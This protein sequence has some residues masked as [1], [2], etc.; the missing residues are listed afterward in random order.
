MSALLARAAARAAPRRRRKLVYSLLA[1]LVFVGLAPLAAFAFKLIDTSR[2]ALV[3][4]QQEIELQLASSIAGQIDTFMNGLERQIN[5]LAD[6]FGAS[7]REQ[8]I[9]R[10]EN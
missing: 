5:T 1:V 3:T 10:F 2:R 7:I 6:S 8:G 4:S 9:K